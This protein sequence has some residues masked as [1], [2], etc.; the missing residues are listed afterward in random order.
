MSIFLC[1]SKKDEVAVRQ[2]YWKLSED[3]F[4]VW[5][6]Q[7]K[8]L[9]G[10][11]WNREIVRAVRDADT[12]IICLSASSV[13]K[14]GYYQK[15]IR[16]TLDVAD[17]K[18]EGALFL[19]PARL[20]ECHVPDRLARFQWVDLYKPVGYTKLIKALRFAEAKKEEVSNIAFDT[21]TK[22]EA[23]ISNTE[24]IS[25]KPSASDRSPSGSTHLGPLPHPPQQLTVMLRSTGNLDRDRRRIK[26]VYGTLISFLGRDR[27]SFQIYENGKGHLIDFVNDTTRVCPELLDR[28]KK[29][30]GEESWRVEELLFL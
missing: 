16:M 26:N 3:G 22:V 27:F 23:G 7:E 1:H 28:L 4:D 17:E 13:I 21:N 30:M 14:S 2:L 10:Q 29:L 6:D 12:V 5:F 24:S 15:E 11:D 19:I 9:P 8:L 18:P 25:S 20:E